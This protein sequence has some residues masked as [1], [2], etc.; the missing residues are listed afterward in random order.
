MT[1]VYPLGKL[2]TDVMTYT[3]KDNIISL[4]KVSG[5]VP[6]N[7]NAIGKYSYEIKN[8]QLFITKIEDACLARGSVDISEALVK[9]K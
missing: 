9:M 3:E 7:N 8:D 2:P 1:M 4:K 5:G 6:C